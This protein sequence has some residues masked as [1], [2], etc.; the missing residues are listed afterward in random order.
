MCWYVGAILGVDVLGSECDDG[1]LAD[2]ESTT[3]PALLLLLALR[4]AI[5]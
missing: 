1:C 2:D 5:L 4:E 3:Q